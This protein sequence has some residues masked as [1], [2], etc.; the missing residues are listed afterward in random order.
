M[1]TKDNKN[2]VLQAVRIASEQW[3]AAFNSGDY[4][5]CAAQ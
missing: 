5:G 4:V 2:K 1:L 3:K